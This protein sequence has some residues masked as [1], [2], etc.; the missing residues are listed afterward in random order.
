MTIVTQLR[1][2]LRGQRHEGPFG[3]DLDLAEQ[4]RRARQRLDDEA[5][6]AF[7][8]ALSNRELLANRAAAEMIR[9]L[10]RKDQ[11]RLA[12]ATIRHRARRRRAEFAD[13]EAFADAVAMHRRTV[14]PEARVARLLRSSRRISAVL[15]GVM[16][17]G[18]V[19]GAVNVQ[20]N[21]AAGL[22]LSDPRF[23]LSFAIEPMV[24]VPLIAMMNLAATAAREGRAIDR[25]RLVL[26]EGALLALV[27]T[28]STGPYIAARDFMRAIEFG[29]APVMIAVVVV[30]HGVAN[31]EFA[32][33]IASSPA[34]A[35]ADGGKLPAA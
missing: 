10:E 6:D 15:T 20:H 1:P 31:R 16:A 8:S 26:V 12:K 35:A 32:G 7:T 23:W 30:M 25:S 2:R 22:P 17:V 13:A 33:M 4:Q 5:D 28:L 27:L 24:T 14:S 19:W 21:V 3:P 9:G 34:L 18:I 11:L 29:V